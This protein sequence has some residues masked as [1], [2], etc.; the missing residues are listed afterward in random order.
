MFDELLSDL[1]A[2]FPSVSIELDKREVGDSVL[3]V[4]AASLFEVSQYLKESTRWDFNVLQVITGHDLPPDF[5]AVTYILASYRQNSE[6]LLRVKLGRQN[7]KVKS[8]V[9]LWPAAN[10]QERECYDM[11]GVQFEGHPDLR[12]IL[13][14]EDWEGFPLRKDYKAAESYNG[15]E[16]YPQEKLNL[17]DRQFGKKGQ[18]SVEVTETVE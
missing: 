2:K 17:A 14:P 10:F 18:K 15:M 5:I 11:L 1:K 6:L 13:C 16:I 12:R 3:I 9:P 7:P 4:D 8:V